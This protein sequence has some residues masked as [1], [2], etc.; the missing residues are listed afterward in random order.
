[1]QAR[2]LPHRVDRKAMSKERIVGRRAG[3]LQRDS[4]QRG[5]YAYGHRG[6]AIKP[7]DQCP[8]ERHSA[9]LRARLP[10][11]GHTQSQHRLPGRRPIRHADKSFVRM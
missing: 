3:G 11:R 10:V 6:P 9:E 2:L 4:M 1:M 8:A 7:A 5:D